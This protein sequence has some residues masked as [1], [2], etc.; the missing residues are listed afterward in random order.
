MKKT[1]AGEKIW[2]MIMGILIFMIILYSVIHFLR[3]WTKYRREVRE[4]QQRQEIME[5]TREL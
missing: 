1:S 4:E 2:A 3:W 5:T